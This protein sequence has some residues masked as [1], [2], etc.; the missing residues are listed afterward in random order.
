MKL[1]AQEEYG[2]RCLLHLA[3]CG[4]GESLT[5]PEISRAEGLSVP[6]VAKLMRLLRMGGMVESAR[7]QSGGYTLARQAKDITV[8]SV[9]NL[10][11]G[12]FFS[13]AFCERHSGRE[14]VCTHSVDCSLRSLWST[15]QMVLAEVLGRTSLADLLCGEREMSQRI[16]DLTGA[17][18]PLVSA[19]QEAMSTRRRV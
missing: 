9:L 13:P 11:G 17:L 1:S 7:G 19:S 10:L 2:L 6:N 5:I 15:V 4:E 14:R 3:R 16:E 18:L 8:V 12:P